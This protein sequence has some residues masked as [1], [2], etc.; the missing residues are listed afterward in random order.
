MPLTVS[1]T[2][3]W[4]PLNVPV[5]LITR[6]P[7]D[8]S[9]DEML[10]CRCS[11]IDATRHAERVDVEAAFRGETHG[12]RPLQLDQLTTGGDERLRRDA[13]PQ[14]GGTAHDVALDH[15]DVGAQRRGD[16]RGRCCRRDLR[17]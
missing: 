10:R 12:L 13:V 1:A 4:G 2:T 5:P 6:T 14:V 16:A 8:W 3:S 9:C 7:C 15:R 17:R 11:S